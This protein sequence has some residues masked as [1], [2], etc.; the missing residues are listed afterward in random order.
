MHF[1]EF[2]FIAAGHRCSDVIAL[3]GGYFVDRKRVHWYSCRAAR[4]GQFIGVHSCQRKSRI[5]QCS[6]GSRH[7]TIL[8]QLKR[9]ACTGLIFLT[10][11]EGISNMTKEI[12]IVPD[13]IAK[14]CQGMILTAALL[15]K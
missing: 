1:L 2:L 10:S 6:R 13:I 7:F 4:Q 8:S 3:F 11:H 14:T 5:T 9:M 12:S 15:M